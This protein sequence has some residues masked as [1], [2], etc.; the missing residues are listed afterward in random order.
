MKPLTQRSSTKLAFDKPIFTIIQLH[1]KD[2][3]LLRM[4]VSFFCHGRPLSSLIVQFDS[5]WPSSLAQNRRTI[6]FNGLSIFRTVHFRPTLKL[7]GFESLKFGSYMLNFWIHINVKVSVEWRSCIFISYRFSLFP[8]RAKMGMPSLKVFLAFLIN[9]IWAIASTEPEYIRYVVREPLGPE[10]NG[11][12]E[13]ETMMNMDFAE[14]DV[15]LKL[16]WEYESSTVIKGRD[17]LTAWSTDH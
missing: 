10:S 14:K 8:S 5:N 2:R 7:W 9:C 11:G 4:T 15:K 3:L 12:I 16:D 17:P 6:H 1:A 13:L